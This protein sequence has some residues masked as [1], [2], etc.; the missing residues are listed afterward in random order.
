MCRA[1]VGS[2]ARSFGGQAACLVIE[3]GRLVVRVVAE[4]GVGGRLLGR[5]VGLV[6]QRAV[7]VPPFFRRLPNQV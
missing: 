6:R 3:T 7:V 1:S 4:I 5:W 2:S